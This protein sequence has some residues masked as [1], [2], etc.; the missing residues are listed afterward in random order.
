MHFLF[1][2]L[3]FILHIDKHLSSIISDFGMMSYVIVF[4]IIFAETGFVF[5]PF[6]PGD[7][8]LFAAG[9]FA[10]IGSLN[11][12]IL[13]I[14]IWLG[15]FFGDTA[16]YWIGHFFGQKIIDNP[17]IPINQEHI[18]KTQK[19]Y[20]KHG[21]KTIFLARFIPIIRTFAPFVAG[22]GKMEYK[23]FIFYNASGGFVWVSG[24]ILAGYFFGNI[25]MVKK[26]FSLVILAI[27]FLSILP[28]IIE[29]VKSKR[30]KV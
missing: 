29:F 27:I 18:D 11:L 13:L 25:P 23:R 30:R 22:V 2:I 17:R 14:I 12:F 6:L 5:T 8:L 16:N 26:N 15:A 3:S 20:H 4:L 7:S 9:T 24:F 19:F 1:G 28:I 10:A 21:G